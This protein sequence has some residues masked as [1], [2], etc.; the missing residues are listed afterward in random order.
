MP[1]L[2]DVII[3]GGGPAGL[4]AA[5]V[6]GRC[7]RKILLFDTGEPRNL[8]SEG[9]HNYL[10]RDH[11]LPLEFI[12]IAHDEIKKYGVEFRYIK[13]THT[14]K[15][16]EGNFIVSDRK[17]KKYL[18][19]K[20]LIATGLKDNLPEIEGF[21]ECYGKTIHHCPYCDGWEITGKKIGVYASQ[22]NGFDLAI[23]LKT[24]TPYVTLFT[25][26]S[27]NLKS[28]QL[29]ILKRYEIEVLKQPIQKLEHKKGRLYNI[30]F[31]NND[32]R[33]CDAIFFVNGYHQQID[34]AKEIGCEMSLKGVVKT[35]KSQ[36]TNIKGL[37]VAG[38]A[39]KD[40][41]FVVVAAAEGA[42]AGVTINKE[43]Q[44]EMLEEM[45]EHIKT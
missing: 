39:S 30:R 18:S 23:S 11:I 45:L 41:H 14:I 2:Y 42:K 31:K 20:L 32:S 28:V 25:D 22:K 4:N 12:K 43:L 38:D 9:M 10:T 33:L 17:G 36:G 13:I 24:W 19:K 44:K 37:F 40:M 27:N 8:Q 5:V 7:H 34:L 29:K 3:I 6:L 15:D 21:K 35:N 1:K 16:S 26:G